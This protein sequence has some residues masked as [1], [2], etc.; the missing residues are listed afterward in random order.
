MTLES[1]TPNEAIAIVLKHLYPL[2]QKNLKK[3]RLYNSH[4][5]D[6]EWL[7]LHFKRPPVWPA[8]PVFVWA[9]SCKQS[10][11]YVQLRVNNNY[12]EYA[13]RLTCYYF[14]GLPPSQLHQASHL[15]E[16]FEGYERNINPHHLIWEP[17]LQNKSRTFCRLLFQM[18]LSNN[19]EYEL[20][21]AIVKPICTL[22]HSNANCIVWRPVW[23]DIPRLLNN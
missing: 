19:P 1:L 2:A 9:V 10:Q 20:A 3:V 21:V 4:L 23:G 12:K 15:L 16:G 18:H 7:N 11:S 17:E 13:H 6:T 22:V 14:H 8:K 5:D